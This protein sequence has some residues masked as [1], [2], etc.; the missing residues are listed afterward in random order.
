M[1][2]YTMSSFRLLTNCFIV[3][4]AQLLI[5]ISK[6]LILR[7]LIIYWIYFPEK[8][9]KR[10]QVKFPIILTREEIGKI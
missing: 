7:I 4:R 9:I 6:F 5:L 8:G 1:I 10:M 3:L 2:E